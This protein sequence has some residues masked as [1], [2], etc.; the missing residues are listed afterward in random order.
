MKIVTVVALLPIALLGC[1]T[2]RSD[3][4]NRYLSS[5]YQYIDLEVTSEYAIS[6]PLVFDSAGESWEVTPTLFY[7][8]IEIDDKT[9]LR[10]G[11]ECSEEI[12]WKASHF[13]SP[14]YLLQAKY[15]LGG[16]ITLSTRLADEEVVSSF[17]FE[18]LPVL[19]SPLTGESYSIMTDTLVVD[20][21]SEYVGVPGQFIR[22]TPCFY[23][24]SNEYL[25]DISE[26]TVSSSLSFVLADIQQ[27]CGFTEQVQ[28]SVGYATDGVIDES[29]AG[30][31]FRV[32]VY[33]PP[34]IIEITP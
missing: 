28:V 26:D 21:A 12:E 8:D 34:S 16:E 33:T 22:F 9:Y 2:E 6:G 18:P 24:T 31:R 10:D 14:L 27:Q 13:C 15:Y 29:L 23:R 3:D 1:D 17:T 30:G 11:I 32:R 19:S 4:P 20:W 5:V 25:V 7:D